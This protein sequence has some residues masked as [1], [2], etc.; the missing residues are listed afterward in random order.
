MNLK[1]FLSLQYYVQSKQY[2]ICITS[3]HPVGEGKRKEPPNGH[4]CINNG[5]TTYLNLTHIFTEVCMFT[6]QL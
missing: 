4:K 1:F 2:M 3:Q 6:T 5:I